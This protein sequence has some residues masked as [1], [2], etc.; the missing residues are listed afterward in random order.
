MSDVELNNDVFDYISKFLEP[1]LN[2]CLVNKFFKNAA[3]RNHS[4]PIKTNLMTFLETADCETYKSLWSREHRNRDVAVHILEKAVGRNIEEFL[5]NENVKRDLYENHERYVGDS[6]QNNCLNIIKY[7]H[8]NVSVVVEKQL[9][10][11]RAAR[12]G[13]LDM[14]KFALELKDK[15]QQLRNLSISLAIQSNSMHIVRYIFENKVDC[16]WWIN[17]L[18]TAIFNKAGLEDIKWMVDN[19][20]PLNFLDRAVVYA[21]R[22]GQTEVV[23]FITTLGA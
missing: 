15:P 11:H 10:M 23:D 17:D 21:Q 9:I 12:H 4:K 22:N 6:L 5:D 19:K 14:F 3:T 18:E 7:I 16:T 20:V 13:N 1:T 2:V 8:S